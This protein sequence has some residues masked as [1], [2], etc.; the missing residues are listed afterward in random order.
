LTKNAPQNLSARPDILELALMIF[1]S[2]AFVACADTLICPV[3]GPWIAS[4]SYHPGMDQEVVTPQ[5]SSAIEP[6]NTGYLPLSD[7][8]SMFYEQ[9]GNLEG[10]PVLFLH[11][12]PG[13]GCSPLHRSLFDASRCRIIMFDQRGCGRSLPLGT[14]EN[15][16]SAD[17]VADIERL[18][19]HLDLD[20]WLVTGGSWGAG[21][22]LA[23]AAAH[24]E[25]CTGLV[26]RG[27]FLGRPSDANWFFHG[28]RD[29]MPDAW[30]ALAEDVPIANRSDLLAWFNQGLH[31]SSESERLAFA[32]VWQRW[33]NALSQARLIPISNI[34]PGSR[35]AARLIDK[36]RLQS[37]YLMHDCFWVDP[38]LLERLNVLAQLPVAILH[39]RLDWICR[40]SAAWDL[41]QCL[42]NSRLMWLDQCG[43]S[44]F[45]PVMTQA[46]IS[47]VSHFLDHGHFAAWGLAKKEQE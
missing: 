39:G 30:H 16:T 24:P 3:P 7:G 46:L 32:Q 26:L 13:G 25:A 12:G 1:M 4:I 22:A 45:D 18:R 44:A 40:P 43:H 38:P 5:I 6:F 9:S 35:E 29:L 41:Y 37:H 11:G 17:L 2:F 8:H 19:I 34:N 23:Y 31:S 10:T 21:L 42:P 33:E 20:R 15:N 14:L 28:A 36:Y 47:V 27:V